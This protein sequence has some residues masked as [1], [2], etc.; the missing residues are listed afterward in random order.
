M[1]G[2]Q[3]RFILLNVELETEVLKHIPVTEVMLIICD[4]ATPVSPFKVNPWGKCEHCHNKH[5]RQQSNLCMAC[6]TICL[7]CK[8]LDANEKSLVCF[9]CMV[10]LPEHKTRAL[11]LSQ[12]PKHIMYRELFCIKF[13]SELHYQSVKSDKRRAAAEQV[14]K[15]KENTFLAT[16]DAKPKDQQ[17]QEL[18]AKL[19]E[20]NKLLDRARYAL[21]L[22]EPVPEYPYF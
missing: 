7:I 19:Y 5:R 20:A 14:K 11:A 6:K 12:T 18:R 2:E 13:P 21:Q 22:K 15:D 9:S 4:F 8:G 3:R 17:N 1:T 10:R 16:E